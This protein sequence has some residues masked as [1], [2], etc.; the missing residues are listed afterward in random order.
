MPSK[1]FAAKYVNFGA[2]D[3]Y[4]NIEINEKKMGYPSWKSHLNLMFITTHIVRKRGSFEN[5]PGSMA[6]KSIKSINI[7]DFY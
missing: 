7:L 4:L 3:I 6:A 1:T 2:C 5:A